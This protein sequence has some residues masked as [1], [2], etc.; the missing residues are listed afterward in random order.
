MRD[1]VGP[2]AYALRSDTPELTQDSRPRIAPMRLCPDF[3]VEENDPDPRGMTVV[4]ADGQVAG[5]VTD[6]WVD[7]AEPRVAFLEVAV[8][9]DGRQALLPMTFV[10][11]NSDKGLVKVASI[12]ARH[13][14]HVPPLRDKDHVTAREEDRISAYYASGHL[15]AVPSRTEPI[16]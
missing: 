3:S 10:R 5:K 4:G 7:R 16:L 2:A 14:A 8:N 9:P 1:A 6:I 13:F 11:I 12:L 15:Y